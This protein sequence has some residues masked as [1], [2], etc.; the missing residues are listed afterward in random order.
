MIAHLVLFKLHSGIRRDDSRLLRVIEATSQLP[1]QIPQLRSFHHG[2]NVTPDPQAWD[3]AVHAVFEDEEAL[4]A[5]FE[6]PAHVPVV[7]QWEEIS[8]F[9]FCDFRF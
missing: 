9:A 8:E 4:L 2:P 5:Y 1:S 7:S 3:Y 6:H